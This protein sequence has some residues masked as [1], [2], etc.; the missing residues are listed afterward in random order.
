VPSKVYPW[1]L[2]GIMQ[3]NLIRLI[4]QEK[5][6]TSSLSL[7]ISVPLIELVYFA[8]YFTC[9]AFKRYFG[10]ASCCLRIF[11][12]FAHPVYRYADITT[13]LCSADR[14]F[15]P[16]DYMKSIDE[17]STCS[18][19]NSR[20]NYC[21]TTDTALQVNSGSGIRICGA[22]VFVFQSVW[23]VFATLLH[24]VGCPAAI[25]TCSL[26]IQAHNTCA[27]G[28]IN[29]FH[30][31]SDFTSRVASAPDGTEHATRAPPNFQAD[32]E[33]LS[34]ETVGGRLWAMAPGDG[35]RGYYNR[36]S[37][38]DETPPAGPDVQGD[39]TSTGTKNMNQSGEAK[40][41]ISL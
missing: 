25:T 11:R 20:G 19:V 31:L 18:G 29:C 8:G 14:F 34:S 24:I 12:F 26:C 23:N 13:E 16:V 39:G 37:Q 38:S 40:K 32:I 30:R 6:F 21:R 33:N 2:L 27:V 28:F 5:L 35:S 15:I 1:I 3:V 22:I 4:T 41:I 9:W 10:G 17:W 7:F 36:V